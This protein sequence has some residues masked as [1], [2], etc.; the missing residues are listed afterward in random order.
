MDICAVWSPCAHWLVR[1]HWTVAH[2]L[3]LITVS[4]THLDVYKRQGRALHWSNAEEFA[5]LPPPARVRRALEEMGP[6][7]VKLGQVL[8]TRVDL[9]ES[10]WIAEFGKLQ[11]L[12]LIH[13]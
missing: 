7:F 13:I 2:W 11:D 5:H 10:E 3:H 8:A 12:S 6:T 4:Y 9:L 1:W